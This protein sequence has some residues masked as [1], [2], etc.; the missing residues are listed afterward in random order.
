[1]AAS[2]IHR[3]S[4]GE[5]EIIILGTAHISKDSAAQVECLIEKEKPDTVCVEL[6]NL[7][8]EALKQK[9]DW[10]EMDI[11]KVVKEGRTALLLSQLLLASFQRKL[12]KKFHILP[13]ADM[14]KAI[15][16]AEK[17]KANLIP[18]DRDIRISLLRTWRK[19]GFLRKLTLLPE[20]ILS[21]FFTEDITEEDIEKL[22]AQD[23]L[24][25]ALRTIARRMPEVKKILID[26]RDQYLAHSL[27]QAPGKKIVAV[28]GAGHVPGVIENLGRTIDI[29]PL[30]TVPPVSPWFKMVGWLLPLFIIGL[31]VAGFSLSGLKT[32]MDMLLKWAAVTASFSGLGAL[33]LLAHP[34][35]ILVA[36][37]SAPIT[38]LH[39]LIAAGWV[40]GL[41][42]ATL[43]KPKVNDFLNLASDITTCRGF[44][45]NKITRVLLLVVVVNLTTSIGTFVAIPVVMR[46]L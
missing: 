30:L 31:F 42:E 27:T 11:V 43:R 19:M 10:Q 16:G 13:G 38:T 17:I 5:R 36:A 22:K 40:A 28:I 25:I 1:M 23:S 14:L 37:L 4:L 45:R 41:T 34:V 6:C 44:F 20:I 8:F 33:L 12:A 24:E 18:A 32:G 2:P 15:E 39:P 3:I 21:L 46:L 9:E 7:R 29:E 35:T 26:E